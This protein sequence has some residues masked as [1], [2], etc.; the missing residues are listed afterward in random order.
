MKNILIISIY[1]LTI[2]MA[3]AQGVGIGTTT[4]DNSLQI[5]GGQNATL[6]PGSGYMTLGN[7][8]N[9]NMVLD[10]NGI[11]VRNNSAAGNLRLQENGG[12][13]YIDNP[14]ATLYV[15]GTEDISLTDDEGLAVLG[16]TTGAN[17]AIDNNEIMARNNGNRTTLYLQNEGGDTNI[18]GNLRVDSLIRGK[19]VLEEDIILLSGAN[20][21]LDIGNFTYANIIAAENPT[22]TVDYISGVA[23]VGRIIILQNHNT[24]T[25]W[26][27]TISKYV[28]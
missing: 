14:Y 23:T 15:R 7:L 19:I 8:A 4:P 26:K 12:N 20:P 25:D 5:V 21:T 27:I 6:T 13:V 28:I 11:Q 1:L 9:T 17:I 2:T 10:N 18:G 24:F 22:P 16:P 3:I